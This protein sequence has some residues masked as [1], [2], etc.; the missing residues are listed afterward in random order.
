MKIQNRC[1]E[2][3][4]LCCSKA[5]ATLT[6]GLLELLAQSSPGHWETGRVWLHPGNLTWLAGK[7]TL[8]EDSYFPIETGDI[9]A[10]YVSLLRGSVSTPR[11]SFND[12]AKVKKRWTWT[13]CFVNMHHR[14]ERQNLGAGL[15]APF[16]FWGDSIL[17]YTW[18]WLHFLESKNFH[19]QYQ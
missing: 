15:E 17:L 6:A 7:W 19:I 8:N 9:P 11:M 14:T 18:A 5:V 10:C 2:L 13:P 12:R 4:A 1:A 16:F 3:F